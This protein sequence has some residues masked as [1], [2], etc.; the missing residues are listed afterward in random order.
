ADGAD[1]AWRV[2]DFRALH[3]QRLSIAAQ[4]D[5]E[6]ESRLLARGYS[7]VPRT[8]GNGSEVD[9]VPHAV[10]EL[11]SSR[12]AS[13]TPQVKEMAAAYK[14]KYGH[15]PSGRTLWLMGQQ[16]AQRTRRPKSEAKKIHG[17]GQDAT[18]A[19]R[20][21]AWEKQTAARELTV[22][23]GV[24]QLVRSEMGRPGV[25]ITDDLREM[26]ARAAVAEVQQHHSV[27]SLAELRFEVARALP[28]GASAEDVRQ[29]ADLAVTPGSGCDVLLVT[30]PEVADVSPLGTRRDGT[31]IYRPPN[32][33]RYTTTGHVDLEERILRQARRELPARVSEGMARRALAGSGLTNEQEDAA[34]RL[35]TTRTAVSVLTAPAGAG[36]THTVAAYAQAWTRLTGR[37]V[38]GITTAE[39]AARQM[40]EEGLAE[41]YNS[42]AFLGR[43]K[44]SDELRYPIP[45][46]EGDVL[47]LDEAGMI[48]T[49]DLALIMD[50]ADRAGA[51]VVPTG[52]PF[53][54]GAVEAGGM[55]G[56]LIEALGAAELSEV[57]R[58]TAEWERDASVRLRAGDKAVIADYD[59][60]G[61]IRGADR[62]ATFSRA[63]GAW[64]ADHLHG[65]E[66]VL[67]AGSNEEAAEL[68]RIVQARLVQAGIVVQPR[69]PLADGNQ[70]G[71][72]DLIRARQN[73]DIDGVKLANRDVLR[74]T[75]WQGDHAE[76]HRKTADGWSAPFLLPCSYLS[77]DAELQYAGNVHVAQGRTVDTAHVLVS[78]TISRRSLYVALTRGRESNIAHVVTGETA[79][80]GKEPYEQ[81]SPEAVLSRAMERDE[82]NLSTLD[83]IRQS[84]EWAT[85]TGHVL[86]LWAAAVRRM[87][88]PAIDA[89][90]RQA[91][92]S[93]EYARY[94]KE[95][96]RPALYEALRE[97]MLAG[98]DVRDLVRRVA[99]SPL[100]G[101]R[102]VSGVLHG[103]LTSLPRPD[104]PLSWAARTPDGAGEIAAATAQ[105]LD[106]RRA[107]LGERQLATPEPWVLRHLG[108]PPRE[109]KPELQALLVHDWTQRAGAAAAYREAAGISDPHQVINWDGHKQNAELEALRAD[110]IHSLQV[111]D[112]HADLMAA[113][114]GQ[115]EAAVIA[116]QRA[117]A[118]APAD[119]SV[120]LRASAQAAQDMRAE[121]ADARV[122][123]DDPAA[124][125]ELAGEI[126]AESANM[127]AQNA[128]YEAWS[129]DTAA[130]REEAGRAQAELER[131]DDQVPE[132]MPQAQDEGAEPEPGPNPEPESEPAPEPEPESE[133][134]TAPEPEPECE[135]E[136][137]AQPT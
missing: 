29:V 19:E 61:R 30:A 38:I 70:A 68:A 86:N 10:M 51:L 91:L 6:M 54:L 116:G 75:G 28:P 60:R 81:A 78:E 21:A 15:E 97:R 84:Q 9:G 135:P 109:A 137:E 93:G 72:G 71:T 132:W 34:V 69:A 76:V 126:D 63:A 113:S 128:A 127:E 45:V 74:V 33:A 40:A 18:E 99:L 85:G 117:R 56:S 26:A 59:R 7:M 106:E 83:Q 55:L 100:T 24:H 37:R 95:H 92:S 120:D 131:R 8:D 87:L 134:E 53:Q 90:F 65:R 104:V 111:Q 125:Y 121:A 46:H 129:R 82:E 66:S 23:S 133:P 88:N 89:E 32:E 48:S 2:P 17:D 14:A 124:W 114:R 67:L 20:L 102:S 80:E 105:A 115:L 25:E 39:N 101:A 122:R 49:A 110:A 3:N 118:A 57:L 44:G 43:V 96:Q 107:A 123:G 47:V 4:V 58:F 1:E 35:L 64:L 22:L 50:L 42:A 73:T 5:R 108:P 112:E 62:E 119:V 130:A 16:A 12:R 98:Q 27:W 52:D 103:R 11:F 79:P 94:E 77:A 136:P 31:S 41:A 13:L 36:K